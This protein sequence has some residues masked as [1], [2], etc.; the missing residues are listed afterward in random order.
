MGASAFG[1]RCIWVNRANMPDEYPEFAPVRMVRDL[2][3]VP[4]LTLA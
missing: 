4:A 1:F 2:S 3:A